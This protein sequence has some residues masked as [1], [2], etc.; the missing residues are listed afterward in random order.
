MSCHPFCTSQTCTWFFDSAAPLHPYLLFV[1]AYPG[2]NYEPPYPPVSGHKAFCKGVGW[3]LTRLNILT[4]PPARR[5]KF[6]HALPFIHATPPDTGM[7]GMEDSS[8]FHW[9]KEWGEVV[10]Q[11]LRGCNLRVSVSSQSF[12]GKSGAVPGVEGFLGLNRA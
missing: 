6:L 7:L 11:H 1:N 10:W 3:G 5:Q 8:F 2:R 9:K 12:K 4:P